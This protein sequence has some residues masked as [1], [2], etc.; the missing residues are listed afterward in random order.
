METQALWNSGDRMYCE[1]YRCHMSVEACIKRQKNAKN[2]G[3]YSSPGFHPGALDVNCRDCK[4]G[5]EVME[6]FGKDEPATQPAGK[7]QKMSNEKPVSASSKADASG[8]LPPAPR[9]LLICQY[10][11][12]DLLET[13]LDDLPDVLK[14]IEET[15][16]EQERTPIAQV[17]YFLKTD[18]RITGKTIDQV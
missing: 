4:Q 12:P 6:K 17:R 2:I 18:Y 8:P 15:A 16:R 13:L 10:Y 1:I 14:T 3:R 9:D 11:P 5:R 7:K